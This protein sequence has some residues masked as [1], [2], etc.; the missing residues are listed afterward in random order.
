MTQGSG[1]FAMDENQEVERGAYQAEYLEGAMLAVAEFFDYA[2]NDYGAELDEIADLFEMS[3]VARALE[4]GLPWAAQGKSGFEL[5]AALSAELGY[6]NA[7]LAVPRYRMD[8]TPEYWAGWVSAYAQ[9]RLDVS[10]EQLFCAM[11]FEQIVTSYHPWHEASEE[12]FAVEVE[13]RL[14]VAPA[15]T[16]L[17]RLRRAAGLSQR[18]LAWRS[19]VSLRSIQMYEQRNKDINKA[20]FCTVRSIAHVLKCPL[21]SLF[22]PANRIAATA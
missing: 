2:V 3:K 19:G 1:E 22:E 13:R 15:E 12:R 14:A 5:F 17:A 6:E 8:K 16:K 20:Q 10:Y 4:A 9:W 18:E 11:P 7:N 21:E